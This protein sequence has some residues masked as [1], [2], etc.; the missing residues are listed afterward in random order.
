MSRGTVVAKRYAKA[1]FQLAQEQGVISETENQLRLIV[2]IVE[3]EPKVRAFLSAPNIT[4]ETKIQT[5]K[6]GLNDKAS[7]IVLNTVSLLLERGR[8]GELGSVLN[9]YLQVAGQALGRAEALVT[10]SKPMSEDEKTKLADKFG[11][12]IGKTVRV[13]NEVNP[14]L[15]GGLT[16]RIGDTLY[17]GSL[18]GK[19][20]RLEKTL[21]TAAI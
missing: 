10:T 3:S 20:E 21:H 12:L 9:A 6:S 15:L 17:D 14:E 5:L 16:V 19:L 1:L 4:L 11:A 13:T 18:K 2:G 7:A 8:E